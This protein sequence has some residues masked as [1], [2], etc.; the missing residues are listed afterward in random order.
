MT[1]ALFRNRVRT[2]AAVL[3]GILLLSLMALH[4]LG[5]LVFDCTNPLC[6][7]LDIYEYKVSSLDE[8]RDYVEG[9]DLY[10]RHRARAISFDCE[11][12]RDQLTKTLNDFLRSEVFLA[13]A[14][15]DGR[16]LYMSRPDATGE[17]FDAWLADAR[18][19]VG[20]DPEQSEDNTGRLVIRRLFDTVTISGGS[21]EKERQATLTL[22]EK[23]KCESPSTES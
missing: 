9:A 3:G 19:A 23:W 20:E 14:W 5:P 11:K 6:R 8:Y 4:L 18:A 15:R 17:A 22:T 10:V 2:V 13:M 21:G 7:V 12:L 1:T 16:V